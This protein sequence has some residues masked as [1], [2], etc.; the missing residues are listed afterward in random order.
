MSRQRPLVEP[1]GPDEPARLS[2]AGG[3]DRGGEGPGAEAAAV[4]GPAGVA[5]AGEPMGGHAVRRAEHWQCAE[6]RHEIRAD[7]VLARER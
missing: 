1:V 2:A 4:G 7:C 6:G 5:G 3:S